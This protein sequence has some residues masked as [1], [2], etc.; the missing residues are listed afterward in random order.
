MHHPG[1]I[2][3]GGSAVGPG[4]LAI[5]VPVA[6]ALEGVGREL[7]APAALLPVEGAEVDLVPELPELP[8][9][10]ENLCPAGTPAP[11]RGK[12]VDRRIGDG[13][14]ANRRQCRVRADLQ[15]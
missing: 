5:A 11:Q 1:T 8:Q 6:L 4:A 13:P 7:R 9:R 10:C 14:R 2:A 15:K 12:P 3:P